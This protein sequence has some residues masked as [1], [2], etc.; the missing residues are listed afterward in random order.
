MDL[1]IVIVLVVLLLA[2]ISPRA[3]WYGTS[4]ALWDIL[5]LIIFIAILVFVLRL[6]GVL[7][8]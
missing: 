2:A 6:L 5:S 8:F 7:A 1:I 3:G 4:S